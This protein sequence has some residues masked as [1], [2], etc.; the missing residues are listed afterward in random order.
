MRLGNCAFLGATCVIALGASEDATAAPPRAPRLAR[1]A[2]R[3]RRVPARYS[4][5]RRRRRVVLARRRF[6]GV[7]RASIQEPETA[8]ST[9]VPDT[10]TEDDL[11]NI[12]F[13]MDPDQAAISNKEGAG[14]TM[15]APDWLTQLNRL[16]GGESEIPAADASWRT[17][18]A[19]SAAASS[20]SFSSG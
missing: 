3:A 8:E 10:W 2:R 17:S 19:F 6:A 1:V 5:R 16:W 14:A 20:S 13:A 7:V 15:A 9:V 11:D 4:G 18:P 12:Q